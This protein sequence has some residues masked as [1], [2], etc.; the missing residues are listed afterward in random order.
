MK[1]TAGIVLAGGRSSRMGTPK[2]ALEWRGSTLLEGIV[3]AVGRA[4]GRVVV[5]RAPGQALPALPAGVAVVEDARPDRGPLEAMLAGMGAVETEAGIVFV[6]AVDLPFLHP[7]IVARVIRAVGPG[8]DA[9][10]PVAGG[11]PQPLAAAYRIGLRPLVA[12]LAEGPTRRMGELLDRARVAWLD[13]AALLADPAVAA[14]DPRL[15]GLSDL[16]TPADLAAARAG[17]AQ[18]MRVNGTGR[19]ASTPSTS[20]GTQASAVAPASEVTA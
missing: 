12:E 6:A 18:V 7:A 13:E 16:D 11:R 8:V 17:A 1:G 10:V 9:A 5:V 4:T 2:A 20:S 19:P 3:E 14:A 15:A